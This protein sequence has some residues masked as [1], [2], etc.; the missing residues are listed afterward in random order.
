MVTKITILSV[1][2]RISGG[3]FPQASYPTQAANWGNASSLE[4]VGNRRQI[5][6]HLIHSP[7]M[8]VRLPEETTLP[9][10]DPEALPLMDL[11]DQCLVAGI[12]Q[13]K[14]AFH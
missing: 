8:P 2:T 6:P 9:R 1:V 5:S 13:S 12:G 4:E 10:N 14:S 11:R 7:G 3:V